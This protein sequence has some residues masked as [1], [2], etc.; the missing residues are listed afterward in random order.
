MD[1]IFPAGTGRR[2]QPKVYDVPSLDEFD[3]NDTETDVW[4]MLQSIRDPEFPYSISQLKVLSPDGVHVDEALS[5]VS[6]SFRPTIE[7]CSMATLIGLAIRI[8]LARHFGPRWYLDIH[9]HPGSHLDETDIN[10]QLSDKERVA[11]AIENTNLMLVIDEMI[12]SFE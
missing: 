4:L 1:E 5:R 7:H 10:K 6:I 8:K 3:L 12:K 2:D 9:V 11:A